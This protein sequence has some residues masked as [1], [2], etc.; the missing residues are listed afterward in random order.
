M[1]A[2]PMRTSSAILGLALACTG[3]RGETPAPPPASNVVIS[4]SGPDEGRRPPEGFA[5]TWIDILP[6][7]EY[8]SSLV[9]TAGAQTQGET[10][11]NG[12]PFAVEG[13]WVTIGPQRYGPIADG[14]RV[15]ISGQG[16]FAGGVLLGPLPERR[17]MPPAGD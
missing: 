7:V 11:L 8:R 5:G 15:E 13:G 4:V 14:V 10:W 1:L 2:S 9:M 12:H 6:G 3:C 17:P 16:V